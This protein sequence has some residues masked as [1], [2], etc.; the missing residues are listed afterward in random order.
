MRKKEGI[1][2]LDVERAVYKKLGWDDPPKAP[3]LSQWEE[4]KGAG[5]G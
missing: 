3:V 1:R 2:A 4:I 5:G